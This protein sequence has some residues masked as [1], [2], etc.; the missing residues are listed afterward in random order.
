MWLVGG[1]PTAWGKLRTTP[2]FDGHDRRKIEACA[3]LFTTNKIL[4]SKI[5]ICLTA[6]SNATW[7][8][9]HIVTGSNALQ[10]F[11]TA[12]NSYTMLT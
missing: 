2:A 4:F 5:N 3:L 11:V 8:A 1:T 10:L 12:H 9:R 6:R 7:R